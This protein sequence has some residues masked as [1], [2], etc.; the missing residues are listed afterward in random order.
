MTEQEYRAIVNRQHRLPGM[1]ERAR[2]NVLA[3][4]NEARRYGMNDLLEPGRQA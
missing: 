4:E 3:L 2:R 1:I